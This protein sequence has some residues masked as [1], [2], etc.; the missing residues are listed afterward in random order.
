[1]CFLKSQARRIIQTFPFDSMWVL[2][3][4]NQYCENG[5][6]I[7]ISSRGKRP[8]SQLIVE[9]PA[10][11]MHHACRMRAGGRTAAA[12]LLM[13]TGLMMC[14]RSALD[15]RTVQLIITVLK[16]V[17]ECIRGHTCEKI[18]ERRKREEAYV[19]TRLNVNFITKP[20]VRHRH[21]YFTLHLLLSSLRILWNVHSCGHSWSHQIRRH[22]TL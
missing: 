21:S 15:W 1:M 16:Y 12:G 10:A 4:P 6:L 19:R 7:M 18:V 17:R 20:K 8:S 14:V 2:V 3:S 5:I 22:E 11:S 9:P 13:M